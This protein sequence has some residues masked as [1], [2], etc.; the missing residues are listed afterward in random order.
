MK[1]SKLMFCEIKKQIIKFNNPG[2]PLKAT[3]IVL[4]N[5]DNLNDTAQIGSRGDNIC[6]VDGILSQHGHRL[7]R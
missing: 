6:K 1:Q 2:T 3:G 5:T 7:C 4:H